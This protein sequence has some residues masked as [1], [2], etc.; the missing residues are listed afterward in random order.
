MSSGWTRRGLIWI[1]T[2]PRPR[3]DADLPDLTEIAHGTDQGYRTHLRR[4]E[5]TCRRCRD[6]HS[7]A[8]GQRRRIPL[9]LSADPQWGAHNRELAHRAWQHG[10]RDE[11]TA[12]GEKAWQQYHARADR[13]GL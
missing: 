2:G 7:R 11:F 13:G 8:N 5:T 10:L 12:A 6:A 1:R 3:D 4:G 9:R